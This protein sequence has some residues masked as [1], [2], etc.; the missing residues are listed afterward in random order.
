[1]ETLQ[2][3]F[4]NSSSIFTFRSLF[5]SVTWAFKPIY[6]TFFRPDNND[7]FDN[8]CSKP[9]TAFIAKFAQFNAVYFWV[10]HLQLISNTKT[11]TKT[12]R[13]PPQRTVQVTLWPEIWLGIIWSLN[14]I[15]FQRTL[16]ISISASVNL[17]M[18]DIVISSLQGYRVS[19]L[20]NFS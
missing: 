12:F 17:N 2:I 5:L 13:E 18:I 4:F 20:F 11:K 15:Q 10:Q 7:T 16:N 3:L 14:F 1:M 9:F 6:I 19:T 8:L